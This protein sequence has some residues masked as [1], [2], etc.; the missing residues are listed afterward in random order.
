MELSGQCSPWRIR[1]AVLGLST[2]FLLPFLV[3][4]HTQPIPSFYAEWLALVL[5][6]CGLPVLTGRSGLHLPRV[7]LLPLCIAAFLLL[8]YPWQA[9]GQRTL[10]LTALLYLVWA[11][12][13]ML[14]VGAL[15]RVFSL[16]RL[17]D[18]LARALILAA[19]INACSL[20]LFHTG[21]RSGWG[22]LFFR[23]DAR[24]NLA[25]VNLLA[26]LI[27]LGIASTLY[28][29]H[30]S[31]RRALM[32]ATVLPVLL[33]AS[34]FTGA[35]APLLYAPW[36]VLTALI[37]GGA[38]IRR[39]AL[40]TAVT[41]VAVAWLV[42]LMPFNTLTGAD[43]V[44]RMMAS[45]HFATGGNVR[46]GLMSIAAEIALAHPFGGAGWGSFAWESYL[47]VS[48]QLGWQGTAEHAHQLLFQMAAELGFFAPLLL[49][50]CLGLW[51]CPQWRQ[52]VVLRT[53][54]AAWWAASAV[55]VILLHAQLE[56]PL[57]YAHFLGVCVVLLVCAEQKT[58]LLRKLQIS[59]G[60]VVCLLATGG[61]LLLSNG[62]DYMQ[63]ESWLYID[64]R[65]SGQT[66]SEGH[67][68]LLAE[69]HQG[70]LM[71]PQASRMLAA[72][73]PPTAERLVGK[74]DICR[75]ALMSEPQTPAV[76]TCALLD[77]LAGDT[78]LAE[79]RW[80]QA[81][82]VF[83]EDA[84]GYLNRLK[85][86]LTAEQ[87]AMHEPLLQVAGQVLKSSSIEY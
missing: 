30:Q 39:A 13:L 48:P 41:Y 18:W 21:V 81:L 44:S 17:A 19:L 57:W 53:Q 10:T 85:T 54:P 31:E 35:R 4:V 14:Q 9:D 3:P 80:R 52:R 29:W 1:L 74:Q 28:C 47:R 65:R 72:V 2:C 71:Q 66:V 43:S 58:Y 62:R 64:M 34:A 22:W 86:T 77:G 6:L 55:G 26:D 84:P 87:L 67:Y 37:L 15:L 59:G 45:A 75:R 42:H 76:F 73:M 49:L 38:R 78:V 32:W 61:Y 69:L 16:N 12:L 83:R 23:P 46:L 5:G 36:L 70:S 50:V 79:Q 20:I 56:Y 8:Q 68:R 51:A 25:Q 82:L 63:L 33:V 60:L 40:F 11:F 7:A 27:W 24:A